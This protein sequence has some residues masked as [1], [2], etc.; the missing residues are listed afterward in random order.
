LEQVSQRGCGV[1]V[2]G[3]IQNVT[4]CSPEQ[5][6]VADLALGREVGLDNT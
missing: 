4:G 1:S 5:P 2:L 3:D 6:A